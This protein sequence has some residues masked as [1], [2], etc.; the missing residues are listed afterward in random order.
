MEGHNGLNTLECLRGRLLAERHASRVAKEEAESLGNKFVELEKKLKEE[1]KLRDKAERKLKLLK[2]KLECFNNVTTPSW[3]K[4]HS[5]EKCEDSCGSSLSSAVSR[6]SEANETKLVHTVNPALLENEVHNHNVAEE[7]VLV[8][9][10]NS[11]FTTKD[12]NSDPSNFLPQ[13]LGNNPNQSSDNLKNDGN[14]LSLSSSKSLAEGYNSQGTDDC[15]SNPS[16]TEA[17]PEN[18]CHNS[19]PIPS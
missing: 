1:I 7:C 4:Y 5:S 13:I 15:S 2:K 19:N 8:Q 6:D 3:Q 10:Q 14:R 11:P 9:T 17:F 16:P 18:I 12:C